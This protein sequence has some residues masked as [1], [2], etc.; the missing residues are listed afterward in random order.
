MRLIDTAPCAAANAARLARINASHAEATAMRARS[1]RYYPA[2]SD[3][4]TSLGRFITTDR[5][6]RVTAPNAGRDT[7]LCEA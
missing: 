2:L 4:R 5:P 6:K 3:G 7:E 1:R